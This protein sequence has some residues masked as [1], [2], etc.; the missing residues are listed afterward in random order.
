MDNTSRWP[1]DE[2]ADA[3]DDLTDA[4]RSG[5]MIGWLFNGTRAC[6]LTSIRVHGFQASDGAAGTT[7]RDL[8]SSAMVIHLGTPEIA[9]WYMHDCKVN[10]GRAPGLVAV[11]LDSWVAAT[12]EYAPIPLV[13]LNSVEMPALSALGA[14]TFKDVHTRVADCDGWETAL[15]VTGAVA[16]DEDVV[17]PKFLTVLRTPASLRRFVEQRS[18]EPRQGGRIGQAIHAAAGRQ[19]WIAEGWRFSSRNLGK[20]PVAAEHLTDDEYRLMY[21]M[22]R[23]SAA[24]P[25]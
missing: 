2:W 17:P 7:A 3:L 16:I 12:G 22:G 20:Y 23:P 11:D 14:R 19:P 9:A 18:S 15:A 21:G 25:R 6:N 5:R 10:S 4:W 8:S 24:T 13:D 1:D